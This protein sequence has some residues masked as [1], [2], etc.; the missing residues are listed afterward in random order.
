MIKGLNL[1]TS[2]SS[3]KI[4]LDIELIEFE[5]AYQKFKTYLVTK[6]NSQSILKALCFL[7]MD[8]RSNAKQ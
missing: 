4:F 7:E 6:G 5:Q 2:G 3:R 1:L 8:S